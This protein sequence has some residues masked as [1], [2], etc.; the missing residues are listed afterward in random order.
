MGNVRV[1]KL[2]SERNNSSYD[3]FERRYEFLKSEL[4]KYQ[5]EYQ[6]LA[7]KVQNRVRLI[8]L[9]LQKRKQLLLNLS[10]EL[11]D[12]QIIK[13]NKIPLKKYFNDRLKFLPPQIN[14][15]KEELKILENLQ[16]I[17]CPS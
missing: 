2:E 5:I 4:D 12:A 9:E 7:N 17:Y 10:T 11:K 1:Y 3:K 14:K 13:E 8:N 6:R 15:C 16:D